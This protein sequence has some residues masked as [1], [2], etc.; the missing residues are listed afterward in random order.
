MAVLVYIGMLIFG[1]GLYVETVGNIIV[2][3]AIAAG[4][5]TALVM[6]LRKRS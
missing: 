2:L 6:R 1:S 3:S 5:A 4:V